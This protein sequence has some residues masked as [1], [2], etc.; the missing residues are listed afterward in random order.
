MTVLAEMGLSGLWRGVRRRMRA[1]KDV[2]QRSG[3]CE[4]VMADLA[5]FCHF[6]AST[7]HPTSERET[8]ILE[9]RRQVYLRIVQH[10]RLTPEEA[11]TMFAGLDDATRIALFDN[12][13]KP[14]IAE[15]P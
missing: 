14:P 2:F 1:Y 9:G 10:L 6:L 5:K 8:W 15:E 13:R 12:H 3:S 11:L 4:A 7:Y